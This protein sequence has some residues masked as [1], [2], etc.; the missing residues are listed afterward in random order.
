MEVEDNKILMGADTR[1]LILTNPPKHT[2][3]LLRLNT[4][5]GDTIGYR[6]MHLTRTSQAP[7]YRGIWYA[8]ARSHLATVTCGLGSSMSTEALT[9]ALAKECVSRTSEED[10]VMRVLPKAIRLINS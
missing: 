10:S 5:K 8:S 9:F 6:H 2:L 7:R 1:T 3:R 4:A